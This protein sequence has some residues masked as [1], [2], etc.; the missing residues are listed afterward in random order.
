[1]PMPDST[2]RNDPASA[3]ISG[4]PFYH[5]A[6]IR[7][8]NFVL[9]QGGGLFIL[10]TFDVIKFINVLTKFKISSISLVAPA[11]A[12]VLHELEKNYQVPILSVV[13]INLVAAPVSQKIVT[14]I[15]KWF[16]NS[17][18]SNSYGLTEIPQK[19]FGNHPENL[20]TPVDSVGYPVDSS[21]IKLINGV[22]A[23]KSSFKSYYQS[24]NLNT[25]QDGYFNTGDIFRIDND[26]F[27]YY[28]DRADSMFKSG[29]EKVY[30][31]HS[32]KT[33]NNHVSVSMSAVVKLPDDIK[34]H[35]AYAFVML[36]ANAVL[37][38]S[39]IQSYVADKLGTHCVPKQV[40]ELSEFPIGTSGKID[41][42]ALTK[43][44][45][46]YSS[47]TND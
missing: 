19:I 6:G 40:W 14:Q 27:Y 45:E 35:K 36:N 42:K 21:D 31:N 5:I 9:A 34:G 37:S 16:P 33:I 29:G 3:C 8:I 22:L 11:M 28:V 25:D 32:E 15:N 26:G 41:Y 30:P 46:K 23:V 20:P 17:S 2:R 38:I 39:D 13:S 43:L 24:T 47:S 44:A 18:V 12:M 10:P 7:A 1:M 4:L